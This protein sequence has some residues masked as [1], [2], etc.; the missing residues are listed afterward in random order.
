MNHGHKAS[1][2][3]ATIQHIKRQNSQ[4]E[5]ADPANTVTERLNRALQDGGPGYTLRLCPDEEYILQ[6]PILFAHPDQEISTSGYPRGNERAML[7]V[8]GPVVNGEGHTVAVDGTC[9]NCDGVKLRN[10]QIDGTRGQSSP[11]KGGG[12]IEMGGDNSNQLIEYVRSFNPR[13]WTCLHIAEGPFT[14]NNVTIQHN[15]LGPCGIDTFQ[16]WAD[17][18]SLACRNSV[19]KDN[20]IVGATDGGIVVFGSPGSLIQNNTI[21]V[22]NNTLLGG[23]NVVD[24]VPFDGDYTGTIIRDNKILGGFATD[25]EEPG[26]TKGNN[27]ENAII[28]IGIAVGPRSWFGDKFRDSRA[29]NGAVLNNVFSGAFSYGIAVSSANNFTVLGNTLVGNTA[30]IGAK[31]PNCSDTDHVPQPGPWIVDWATVSTDMNAGSGKMQPEFVGISDGDSLTCVLPPNGGDFWPFGLNPSNSS[32][33]VGG[34]GNQGGDQ[35]V[36]GGGSK[37]GVAV[38]VV[39][40]ILAAALLAF[41]GRRYMLRKAEERRHFEATKNMVR[42]SAYTPKSN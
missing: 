1:R 27:F 40:A 11:T 26:D 37:A 7:I 34:N 5:P 20:M 17:G 29:R 8:G 6:A 9:N 39:F 22:T 24:Y 23:I 18:I 4:C 12:N 38:G 13:S 10:I 16:E 42:A 33:A 14:C 15:D 35:N 2:N 28:K 19:V 30:F 31:G 25:G 3:L 36:G 41:F 32:S 21:W